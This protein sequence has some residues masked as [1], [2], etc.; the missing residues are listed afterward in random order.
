MK[1]SDIRISNADI[2]SKEMQK[3]ASNQK[4]HFIFKHRLVNGEIRDVDVYSGLI[5]QEGKNL[6]YSIIHDITEQKKV[7]S[8]LKESENKFRTFFE[9]IM[10]AVLLTIPD[11]T[12]LAA[13]PPAEKL[14][15]YT[16]EE[17]CKIGRNCLVDI[18]DPNLSIIIE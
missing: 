10:D 14:F 1:I 15:G 4:N 3:A 17:I 5:K 9:N 11:G 2:V 13:N 18:E 16:E 8:K 7:E 6:L 12:I